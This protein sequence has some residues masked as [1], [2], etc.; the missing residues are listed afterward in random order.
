RVALLDMRFEIGDITPGLDPLAWPSG[1]A[2]TLQSLA[3]RGAIVAPAN[4]VDLL[5]GEHVGE[6]MAAEKALVVAFLVGPGGDVDAEPGAAQLLGEPRPR[7][8]INRRV[9]RA[10]HPGLVPAKLGKPP[11]IRENALSVDSR[12]ATSSVLLHTWAANNRNGSGRPF[13]RWLP[14]SS[15]RRPDPATRSRTVLETSTSPVPANP[16]TRAAMCTAIPATSSRWISISPVCRPLRTAIPSGRTRSTIAAAQ[17]TARAGPSKVARN[18]SP[19]VL[20]SRPRNR[21]NSWR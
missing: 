9:G 19:V 7:L 8:D 12:H 10:V 3:Q 18:P 13:A 4:L 2:G 16:T 21:E 20:I 14:R 1:E 15:K 11:Q 17:R 6:G 5:F